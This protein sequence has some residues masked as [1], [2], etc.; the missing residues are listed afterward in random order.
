MKTLDICGS[1]LC[2]LPRDERIEIC[3]WLESR[4]LTVDRFL[5]AS[6]TGRLIDVL[7]HLYFISIPDDECENR[8]CLATQCQ[9]LTHLS[10][11]SGWADWHLCVRQFSPPLMRFTIRVHCSSYLSLS[12]N[13]RSVGS[14]IGL[15][16][17]SLISKKSKGMT[18]FVTGV[19]Q[20]PFLVWE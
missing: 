19:M 3:A 1:V 9:T 13:Q 17:Y 6:T 2:F 16:I 20:S 8:R 15:V 4:V 12:A 7:N 18:V 11:A 14:L 10:E 5:P